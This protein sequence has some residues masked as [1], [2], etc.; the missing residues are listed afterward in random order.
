MFT[1]G[2]IVRPNENLDILLTVIDVDDD[3]W[4]S[5]E[6]KNNT[7]FSYQS[8]NIQMITKLKSI[9]QEPN[10]QVANIPSLD[11]ATIH[12]EV[13]RMMNE[14][15][16]YVA[17]YVDG[18]EINLEISSTYYSGT[19]MDVLFKCSIG[20]GNE[21][22]SANLRQSAEICLAH[23]QQKNALKPLAIGIMR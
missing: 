16:Q 4:V 19:S 14:V 3:G 22:R 5:C 2:D 18:K 13:A 23:W 9:E 20:Y 8:D 6:D 15:T 21:I 7:P 17:K 12:N 10:I 1:V 11:E